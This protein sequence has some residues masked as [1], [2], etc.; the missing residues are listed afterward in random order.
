MKHLFSKINMRYYLPLVLLSIGIFTSC[1]D[2]D[3][4]TTPL[5]TPTGEVYK[6]TVSS[7]T[8]HWEN[9]KDATQYGYELMDPENN[10]V[11]GDVTTG[12][13]ATFT[14]LKDNTT[15]TLNVWAYSSFGSSFEKSSIATLTG[16]TPAIVQLATPKLSVE[17]NGGA[18][19]T[20]E[21]VPNATH[22]VLT[23]SI[24]GGT[25]RSWDITGTEITIGNLS[26]GTYTVSLKA[27]SDDEAFSDSEVATVT[28]EI[29]KQEAWRVNGT[30][31]DGAGNKW[32]VTM[33]AW[34]NGTYTLKN[35]YNV[36]GFDLEFSVNDDTSINILNSYEPYLPN[37]WV[38][39]G[40]E[41]DNGWVELYTATN[42]SDFYSSFAGSKA[43]GGSVWFYSYKTSGYAEFSWSG[44]GASLID[45]IVGTY[46]QN[47]KGTDYTDVYG[48][49]V[50]FTATNDVTIEKTGDK[51][52]K[53]TGFFTDGTELTATLD[54]N[55]RTLTF[56]I[57]VW[58]TYYYF[59]AAGNVSAPVVA[60]IDKD[61]TISFS[62][63]SAMA[64]YSGAY[65]DYVSGTSTTLSKK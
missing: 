23:I 28:F 52:I 34:N 40:I 25:E 17:V 8:F 19:A 24:D 21:E 1:K 14:G 37:I 15:Y 62:D 50:E 16:T 43:E 31:D 29:E 9:I 47:G 36:E 5:Q 6:A 32:D 57:S 20:W 4:V 61:G 38:N 33:I 18:L 42:G 11:Y 22:Y 46:S 53:M 7:L 54:E 35:W 60:T 13:T 55:A 58:L 10:V 26:T 45:E 12:T 3:P 51:T 27:V 48:Y 63:W 39:A 30:F 44:S 64:E 49:G 56:D 41:E 59:S 2:E 65:Y